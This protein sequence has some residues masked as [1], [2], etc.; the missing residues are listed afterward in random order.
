MQD[1]ALANYYARLAH[2][3]QSIV[4]Y[5]I[6]KNGI[7]FA[8]DKLPQ[9]KEEIA[10]ILREKEQAFLALV[11]GK[12][13]DKHKDSGLKLTRANFLRDVFYSRQGFHLP[14]IEKTPSGDPTIDRK[15]LV[16]LR[17]DLDDCPAKEALSTLIEWGTLPKALFHL[18]Q[19]L[20]AGG[21]AGWQ[22]AH[23]HNQVRH[24]YWQ[25]FLAG[26]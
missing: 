9:A 19:G 13:I 10:T 11:P 7:S 5:E 17:D 18:P 15:V 3:V 2:P 26:T 1:K 4:L 20:W 23:D 8:A 14:V 16:R 24:S 12:V 25:K 21:Q 22:A 6:E